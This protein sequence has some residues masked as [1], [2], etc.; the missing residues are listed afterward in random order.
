MADITESVLTDVTDATDGETTLREAVSAAAAGDRIIFDA[1]VFTADTD[2]L[3]NAT[4]ALTQGLILIDKDLTFD[5]DTNGD[6]IAD[7]TIDGASNG[8]VRLFNI[9][10]SAVAFDSLTLANGD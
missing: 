2:A 9:D 4:I 6:G 7:V 1:S 8:G 5:G 10:D 3:T